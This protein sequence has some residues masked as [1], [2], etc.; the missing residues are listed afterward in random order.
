MTLIRLGVASVIVGGV[1]V[2]GAFA[3]GCGGDDNG[4]GPGQTGDDSG[5]MGDTTIPMGGDGSPPPGMDGSKPPGTDGGPTGDADAASA[6]EH[7]KVI[8]VHGSAGAPPLRFCYGAV[9]TFDGGDAGTVKML[10]VNP[11]PNT[12]LGV[13]PGTGGP[14]ADT[15]RDLAN[16]ALEVFA[17][18]A[19]VLALA[20]VTPDAG[21]TELTCDK[22]LGSDGASPLAA[23]AG[24]L[25][26]R[27]G[28]DYWDIGKLPAGT[29]ADGTTTL[30]VVDGCVPGITDTND[31]VVDCPAGY[32]PATGDLGMWTAKLDRTAPTAG[33]I[34]AQFAYASNPFSYES[35]AAGG[36]ATVAGFFTKMLVVPDAGALESDGGDAGDAAVEAAAPTPVL[37][38]IPQVVASGVTNGQLSPATV[39]SIS[40][41]TYDG[42]SGFFVNSV[43]IDGGSN[44]FQ[45]GLT[46]PNIQQIS[47]PSVPLDA[48]YFQNG[49]GYVFVLVGDP[50]PSVPT[51]L[52]D[53]GTFNVQKV[54]II[55]FPTNPPFGAN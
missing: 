38:T 32:N 28:I 30:I 42:T 4:G 52:D 37:V 17:V 46:L 25:G 44:P 31:Q 55:S 16:T 12:S 41:I 9:T 20:N 6:P 10:P 24:G 54:H 15:S 47:A 18:S 19:P 21:G 27:P 39:K 14:G 26:L 34:G 2:A 8:L 3:A 11:S 48:G 45:V 23:D 50:N 33:S 13:P 7:G 35:A 29:L 1:V 49:A 51:F 22:I 53:A 40:G 43:T 5:M 36:V